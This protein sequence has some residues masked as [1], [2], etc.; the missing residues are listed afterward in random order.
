MTRMTLSRHTQ[1]E[2]LVNLLAVRR[3]QLREHALR[4]Q[5]YMNLITAVLT[6]PDVEV[7]SPELIVSTLPPRLSPF[8][9]R[10]H[11]A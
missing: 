2:D 8:P 6:A 1:V 4:Q 9:P 10:T 11:A 7:G 5:A 3:T